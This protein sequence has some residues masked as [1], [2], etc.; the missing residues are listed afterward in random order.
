MRDPVK[1]HYY[2]ILDTYLENFI[3]NGS[4]NLRVIHGTL[5]N[6]RVVDGNNTG[7]GSF[8]PYEYCWFTFSQNP[9]SGTAV[10]AGVVL[11]KDG[12]VL[13]STWAHELNEVI[14]FLV[15]EFRL[16]SE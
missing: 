10:F 11:K 14:E 4:K 16:R 7:V 12:T 5:F 1:A 8:N 13:S 3:H 15:D 6:C 9:K 2:H